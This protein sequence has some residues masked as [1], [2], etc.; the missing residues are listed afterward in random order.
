MKNALVA[1]ALI[2]AS[3]FAQATTIEIQMH[4]AYTLDTFSIDKDSELGRYDIVEGHVKLNLKFK[5]LSLVLQPAFQCPKGMACA[6]VMPEPIT[7]HLPIT[8]IGTGFCGGK[9]ISA[10]RDARPADGNLVMVHIVDDSINFCMGKG[11]PQQGGLFER[12][13]H[14]TLT[15]T[16]ARG[17]VTTMSEMKGFPYIAHDEQIAQ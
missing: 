11:K 4:K 10:K 14:V 17:N 9:I 6:A 1:L 12:P 7:I 13:V 8:Y 3:N 5:Q 16:T 15:E 2:V